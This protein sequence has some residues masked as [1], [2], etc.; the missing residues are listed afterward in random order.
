M[1]TQHLL[2]PTLAPLLPLCRQQP[3][4]SASHAAQPFQ[5][6]RGFSK[7]SRL[8]AVK[9]VHACMTACMPP[10]GGLVGLVERVGQRVAHALQQAVRL[11]QPV[12]CQ[13]VPRRRR[14]LQQPDRDRH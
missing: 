2:R 1:T 4:P 11:V 7:K 6:W 12:L 8:T 10:A 9:R 3:R 5:A 14:H 13:E